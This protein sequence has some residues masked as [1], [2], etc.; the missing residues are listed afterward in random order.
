MDLQQL[1]ECWK[2]EVSTKKKPGSRIG[3]F[4]NI[5]KRASLRVA[6]ITTFVRARFFTPQPETPSP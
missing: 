4:S 2:C 1:I 6:P 3:L 5:V